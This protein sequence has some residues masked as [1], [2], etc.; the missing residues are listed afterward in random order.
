[1][2]GR[3][4]Q[5]QCGQLCLPGRRVRVRRRPHEIDRDAI[6][7]GG[8]RIAGCAHADRV[9]GGRVDHRRAQR[10]V[11][12]LA[13]QIAAH[14]GGLR[15]TAVT[16]GRIPAPGAVAEHA[17]QASGDLVGLGFET[18]GAGGDEI[19]Q[20]QA[21]IGDVHAERVVEA[22]LADHHVIDIGAAVERQRGDEERRLGAHPRTEHEGFDVVGELVVAAHEQ[23]CAFLRGQVEVAIGLEVVGVGIAVEA[24]EVRRRGTRLPVD[25][26]QHDVGVGVGSTGLGA[27]GIQG[28]AAGNGDIT[29]YHIAAGQDAAGTANPLFTG[30]QLVRLAGIAA[31]GSADRV[32]LV[33]A[34]AQHQV[35]LFTGQAEGGIEALCIGITA[36]GNA[37]E[38]AGFHAFE[39]LAQDE[40]DHAADRIG[41]IDGRGAI[42]QY[43]H[44]FNQRH[45]DG[46]HVHRAIGVGD[47]ADPA[48]AVHQHQRAVHAQS[49][50]VDRRSACAA[51][52]VDLGIGCGTGDGR[53]ALQE[54]AHRGCAGAFDALAV[55]GEYRAG[56]F[57]VG[58]LDARAG[59]LDPVQVG[60]LFLRS[61]L[62]GEG[63]ARCSQCKGRR[64]N[65]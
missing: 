62:L 49:A 36:R 22:V 63:A 4:D 17:A 47:G 14:G 65:G 56:G 58:A 29:R 24:A 45:R 61:S 2:D 52:V 26:G 35:A 18:R 38:R 28:S 51:T 43:F 5:L 10:I 48:L 1:M 37:V 30:I 60:G 8:C 54:F 9:A 3:V 41:A 31:V 46:V 40:V 15:C 39:I 44:A 32:F 64:R 12:A 19:T 27:V 20:A 42:L 55:N 25:A 57:Q 34:G 33:I 11:Q 7:D 21:R 23:R 16:I 13:D 53:G 6:V 59:D 50:Q